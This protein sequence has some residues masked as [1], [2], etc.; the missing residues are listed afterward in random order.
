MCESQSAF[1]RPNGHGALGP[2]SGLSAVL[3]RRQSFGKA[4]E[5][6]PRP[7]AS[8]GRSRVCAAGGAFS[9]NLRNVGGQA[10]TRRF[11]EAEF[12]C[13]QQQPA[14]AAVTRMR[15]GTDSAS[16]PRGGEL[17]WSRAGT[18]SRARRA[19]QTYGLSHARSPPQAL[20]ASAVPMTADNGL[21]CGA[22]TP[23]P[24]CWHSCQLASADLRNYTSV[25]PRLL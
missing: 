22:D 20:A 6:S 24:Q 7:T 3:R 25:R 11:I 2:T 16:G 12:G 23:A 1:G 9:E 21:V 14:V 5:E 8:A 13:R 19:V 17:Q 18:R 15:S 10:A 4:R